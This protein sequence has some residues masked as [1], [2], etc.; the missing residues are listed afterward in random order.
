MMK[1]KKGRSRN[2]RNSPECF[3]CRF[4]FSS[5]LDGFNVAA[6]SYLFTF[7]VIPIHVVP[8]V[9]MLFS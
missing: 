6:Y 8:L 3:Q 5:F 1:I 7:Y 4:H 2:G 9:K